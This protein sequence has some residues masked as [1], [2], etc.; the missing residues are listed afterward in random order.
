M[1]NHVHLL[2]TP[3]ETGS[4]SR[5]MQHVGRQYVQYI[6][7]TYRRSGALWEGRHK[8]SLVD[9]ENYLLSCYRY[10]ELNPVTAC[11]V[12]R[13]EEYPWSSY[14][15]NALAETD[16]LIS[17]HPLFESLAKDKLKRESVYQDLFRSHLTEKTRNDISASISASRI[18][19]S[20]RF[21]EQ[22]EAVLGR[23]A[24]QIGRGRPANGG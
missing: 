4:I 16:T 1:T 22:V 15:S 8:S 12:D 20:G 11:M 14:R 2:V 24:G 21:K 18:L 13:P 10:I 17:P 5:L 6:N 19:G 7:K 23:K 3:D 9:A